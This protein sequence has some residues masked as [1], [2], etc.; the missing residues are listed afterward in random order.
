MHA[1]SS[2]TKI[3][4]Q[5]KSNLS[6]GSGA[7]GLQGAVAYN[8]EDSQ[9]MPDIPESVASREEEEDEETMLQIIRQQI[10]VD[11]KAREESQ[12]L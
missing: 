3:L 1:N 9:T 8:P 4:S 5:N 7:W 11:R 6:A 2:K 12:V 10:S